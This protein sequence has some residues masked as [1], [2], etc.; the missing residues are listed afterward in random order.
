MTH[1]ICGLEKD[2]AC[3]IAT[4]VHHYSDDAEDLTDR[5]ARFK[6]FWLNMTHLL[7]SGVQAED[8]DQQLH[9]HCRHHAVLLALSS[10]H[11]WRHVEL[12]QEAQQSYLTL[13]FKP[14]SCRCC[15]QSMRQQTDRHTD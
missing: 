3:F 11:R 1:T 2:R 9:M 14:A 6:Q 4:N 8:I 13:A 12:M 15:C 10:K 5:K 7:L